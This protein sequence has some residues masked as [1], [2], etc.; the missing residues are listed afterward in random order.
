MKR[1][2][3]RRKMSPLKINEVTNAERELPDGCDELE[4]MSCPNAQT[5][6]R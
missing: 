5:R 6:P 4:D 2:K 3:K 1:P